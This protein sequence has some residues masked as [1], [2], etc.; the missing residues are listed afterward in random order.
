MARGHASC[1]DTFRI[2]RSFCALEKRTQSYSQQ[3]NA[4]V[5]TPLQQN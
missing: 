5:V 3:L 4:S 1:W 2:T